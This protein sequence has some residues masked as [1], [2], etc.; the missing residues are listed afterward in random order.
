MK[1]EVVLKVARPCESSPASW[2]SNSSPN[3]SGGAAFEPPSHHPE[4][5][6]NI[7]DEQPPRTLSHPTEMEVDNTAA[8]PQ[9]LPGLVVLDRPPSP[10]CSHRQML[11]P[12]R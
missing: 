9:H 12:G 7:G 1:L 4:D 11:E 5:D 2:S 3:L 6:D 8:A 10:V